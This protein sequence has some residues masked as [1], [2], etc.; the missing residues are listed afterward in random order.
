MA[1]IASVT[2]IITMVKG[3]NMKT[4]YKSLLVDKN[5]NYTRLDVTV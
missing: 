4:I 1:S 3:D 2:E 5:K